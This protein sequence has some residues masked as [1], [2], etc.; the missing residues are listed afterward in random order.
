MPRKQSRSRDDWRSLRRVRKLAGQA[1][2]SIS[3]RPA[4]RDRLNELRDF[5]KVD[6]QSMAI[7]VASLH[8]DY[9]E[10]ARM[11]YLLSN[12]RR[13]PRERSTLAD[14]LELCAVM[15]AVAWAGMA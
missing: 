12:P 5:L 8:A 14:V 1:T 11:K 4:S 15:A 10:G 3:L 7:D 6:D 13:L 9:R 2:A